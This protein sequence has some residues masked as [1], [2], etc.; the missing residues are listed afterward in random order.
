MM[1][2]SPPLEF[3]VRHATP[4]DAASIV[5]MVQALAREEGAESLFSVYALEE[6]LQHQ[7]HATCLVVESVSRIIGCLL[8]YQGYDI[9]SCSYGWHLSDM[10]VIPESRGCGVGKQLIAEL[11]ALKPHY[12][13]ISWTVLRSNKN[14]RQFYASLHAEEVDVAFMAIGKSAIHKLLQKP[15]C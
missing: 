8:A 3:F 4:A 5:S 11:A 2:D 14:A 15:S 7:P 6:F 12:E 10:Y 1:T 9:Q 13:W